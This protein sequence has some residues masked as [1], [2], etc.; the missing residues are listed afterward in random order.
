MQ[1]TANRV[2]VIV[3]NFNGMPHIDL[4]LSSV[5]AQTYPDFEVILVDNS[6]SDGSLE[7]VRRCYPQVKIIANSENL[8]YAGGINVG[9]A[10]SSGAYIAPLNMDTEVADQ[11]LEFMARFLDEN[12]KAGAVGPKILLFD[13]RSRINAL[14]HN[15]HVTGLSFCRKL[16][17]KDEGS[18][19]PEAVVGVSGCSYMIRRE[20]LEQMGGIPKECFMA[21]DDVVVSWMLNLMGYDLY[22]VP[23]AVVYHKYRL[24]M[25]PDKLFALEKNRLGVVLSGFEPTTLVILSPVLLFMELMIAAY[26]LRGGRRHIAAKSRAMLSLYEDRELIRRRHVLAKRLRRISDFRM[27]RRLKWNPEWGQLLHVI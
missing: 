13:D 14:G 19:S 12:R 7:H 17:M 2:S 18:A 21:N 8:G 15:I 26:C 27:L 4:C 16:G 10:R 22:C 1:P 6:S 3:V 20:L 24:K 25:N 11:W 5:L 23:R 9:L